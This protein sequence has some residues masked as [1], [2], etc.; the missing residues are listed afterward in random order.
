MHGRR[1]KHLQRCRTYHAAHAVCMQHADFSRVCIVPRIFLLSHEKKKCSVWAYVYARSRALLPC[2]SRVP[3][4]DHSDGVSW[5]H[6]SVYTR[7]GLWDG[8]V[9][10]PG[11][12]CVPFCVALMTTSTKRNQKGGVNLQHLRSTPIL[13]GRIYHCPISKSYYL[14]TVYALHLNFPRPLYN[15][16]PPLSPRQCCL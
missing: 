11:N 9:F 3:T 12:V 10:T 7:Q 6:G 16:H 8:R 2:T 15:C 14:S 13:Q 1:S 5:I 4:N